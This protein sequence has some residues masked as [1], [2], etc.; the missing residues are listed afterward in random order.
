MTLRRLPAA[1]AI[2]GIVALLPRSLL[3]CAACY[4]QSDSAMAA[5]MNWGIL[6]LLGIILFMLGGVA[7]FFV[8]LARR[9]AVLA[10][11]TDSAK[12]AQSWDQSWPNP[13]AEAGIAQ[14]EP[15]ARGGFTRASVLARQ[16]KH[17]L[18]AAPGPT[19]LPPTRGR[20]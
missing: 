14:N 17:C 11:T 9:S 18:H 20:G 1:T 19:P 4:G 12:L 13:K 5:G 8:F 7:G 2:V 16:R 10:K 15:L 3:A 6:S